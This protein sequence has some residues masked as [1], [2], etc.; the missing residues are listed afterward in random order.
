M[1][2]IEAHEYFSKEQIVSIVEDASISHNTK[3]L[4]L[5]LQD[6]LD[7]NKADFA[8]VANALQELVK[9]GSITQKELP[10]IIH[11]LQ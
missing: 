11:A 7:D 1:Q 2:I 8:L 9:Q 6:L 3:K 5:H 10:Q 4:I